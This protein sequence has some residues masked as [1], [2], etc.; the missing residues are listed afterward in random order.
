MI[1]LIVDEIIGYASVIQKQF[2]WICKSV[3]ALNFL[4]FSLILQGLLNNWIL[5]LSTLYLST[6][7]ITIALTRNF[8]LYGY[9]NE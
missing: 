9:F 6:L 8:K 7:M 1:Y 4:L 3:I 2:N 5:C